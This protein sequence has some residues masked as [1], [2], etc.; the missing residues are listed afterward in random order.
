MGD[1]YHAGEVYAGSVPI[2]DTQAS[3]ETVYSSAKVE[4]M[5]EEILDGDIT[6]LNTLKY[7]VDISSYTQAS[8]Y[9][10]PCDGYVSAAG[11]NS[12][13]GSIVLAGS[14]L[15]VTVPASGYSA[16]FVKKGLTIYGENLYAMSFRAFNRA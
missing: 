11:K 4:T 12:S 3:E 13:T 10:A 16:I 2:D 6:Y 8:P 15:R 14:L 7:N 1:I 5:M 9:M